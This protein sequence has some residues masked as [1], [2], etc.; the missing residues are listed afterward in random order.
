[1]KV[2]F[3]YDGTLSI[4]SAQEY[5]LDLI[6][7]GAEVWVTTARYNELRKHEYTI[8]PTNEDMYADL[9]RIGLSLD[10]VVFTNMEDKSEFLDGFDMHLDDCWATVD[11]INLNSSCLAIRFSP[12]SSWRDICD[13]YLD[14]L[15]NKTKNPMN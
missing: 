13:A 14:S 8:N 7:R 6:S 9:K 11:E 1:M 10:K 3:D 12:S 15:P 2:S 4:P 5:C